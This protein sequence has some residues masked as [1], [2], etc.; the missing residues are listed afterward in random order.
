[1]QGLGFYGKL[2]AHGDFV[3]RGMTPALATA[4]DGWLGALM[5]AVR[6]DLGEDDWLDVYLT[7]PVWRFALGAGVAGVAQIGVMVPS[8]DRVGRYFPL[9]LVAPLTESQPLA[10]ALRAGQDLLDHLED[11]ACHVLDADSL[12]ADDL[13]ASLEALDWEWPAE[14]AGD[15]GVCEAGAWVPLGAGS[16]ADAVAALSWA[17]AGGG[18]MTLA[19]RDGLWWSEGSERVG[20]GL[21]RTRGWPPPHQAVALLDGVWWARGWAG[22][23][24]PVDDVVW[25]A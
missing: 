2:P 10:M 18:G 15:A 1:M 11:L 4:W 8:V 7:S 3:R 13:M 6:E 23:T 12:E 21:V 17:L 24:T 25:G 5:A 20:R 9:V 14:T 22:R 19:G 16:A